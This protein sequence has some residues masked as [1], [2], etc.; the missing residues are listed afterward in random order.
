[1]MTQ[2]LRAAIAATVMSF[3]SSSALAGDEEGVPVTVEVLD[4]MGL[5]IATADRSS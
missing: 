4:E 1:M 5:P 3:A 2:F